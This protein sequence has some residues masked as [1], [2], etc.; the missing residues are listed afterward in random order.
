M[1]KVSVIMP[2]YNSS[3]FISASIRSVISQT[4]PHWELIIVDDCSA[5]SSVEAIRSFLEI[6]SR[7]TLI[8]LK[9]N[10][11]AAI[12]RN[13]AIKLAR[14]RFIAF[15]DSD[16][17]WHP[18]KL[19]KQLLFM[20]EGDYAFTYTGYEKI[21]EDGVPFGVMGAPKSVNYHQLLKTNIIGCLSAMYDTH[22]LD[23]VYMPINTKR[24]DFAT[25]LSILK[26]VD[27]AHGMVD[28]LAQYRVYDSQSSAKKAKMAKENWRLYR[29]I[30]E[31]SL[32]KSMYYFCHYAVRGALR[33]KSP[34]F[35]RLIGLID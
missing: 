7:I 12:A 35:A 9:D 3:L 18:E 24:E 17:L 27:Y 28:L 16:D 30:E 25:W 14:G 33:A 21:N 20:S 11:G 1:I 5:D 34:K 2:S 32:L 6:D 4:Y 10:S 22:K 31:L 29:E 19:E 23:K 26:K 15:L 13:T 8:Q